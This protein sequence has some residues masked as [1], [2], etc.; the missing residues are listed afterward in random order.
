MAYMPYNGYFDEAL[1]NDDKISVIR[2]FLSL[3][4]IIISSIDNTILTN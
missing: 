2:Q 1:I 4:L 3:S